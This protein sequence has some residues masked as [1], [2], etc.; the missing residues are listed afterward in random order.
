M[1]GFK[2]FTLLGRSSNEGLSSSILAFWQ[3]GCPSLEEH[4]PACNNAWLDRGC[5]CS[6]PGPQHH[7]LMARSAWPGQRG[8]LDRVDC[9]VGRMGPEEAG[10]D[11]SWVLTL[12]FSVSRAL[13]LTGTFA[14]DLWEGGRRTIAL[15]LSRGRAPL[16]SKFVVEMH[17]YFI[18]FWGHIWKCS[19]LTLYLE[20][21]SGASQR[22]IWSARDWTLASKALSIVLYYR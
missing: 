9:G 11:F 1:S 21:I 6:A 19:E 15:F 13:S 18:S 10:N 20:I 3:R 17:A 16:L 2:I 8:A 22:T 5:Q 12:V 14:E 7:P 4:S